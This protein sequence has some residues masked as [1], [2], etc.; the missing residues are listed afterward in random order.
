[1]A[2][3]VL[4]WRLRR[5]HT[6][7]GLGL[8]GAGIGVLYQVVFAASKL[9]QFLPMPLALAVMIGLVGLSCTLAVLQDSKGLAISGSIG[10]FLAPVLM[11]TGS[12][13]HVRCFRITPCSI[14]AFSVL[15]GSRPGGS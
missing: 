9:Y 4:G 2:L 5:N 12:G 14:P 15:P 13:S 6:L 8:E 3:L 7:Y 1:M 11:S 10:G